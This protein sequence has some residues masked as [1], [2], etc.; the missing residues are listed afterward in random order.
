MAVQPTDKI[1]INWLLS[2]AH[3]YLLQNMPNQAITILELLDSF[4]PDHKQALRMLAYG[5]LQAKQ[6]P[7]AI[8]KIDKL[9]SVAATRTASRE[10]SAFS[11]LLRAQALWGLGEKTQ[12]KAALNHY[13]AELKQAD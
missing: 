8:K 2:T 13:I 4:Y 7:E 10:E 12:A 5:Y 1:H 11:Q 6:F 3:A 9:D